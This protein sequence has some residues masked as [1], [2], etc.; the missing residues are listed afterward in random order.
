[1]SSLLRRVPVGLLGLGSITSLLLF[2]LKKVKK[3]KHNINRF[4][5]HHQLARAFSDLGFRV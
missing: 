2:S 5:K 3:C 4:K 1:M